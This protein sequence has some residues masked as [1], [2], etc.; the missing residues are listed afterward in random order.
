MTDRVAKQSNFRKLTAADSEAV[1]KAT[2]DPNISLHYMAAIIQDPLP[3]INPLARW[4]FRK[5]LA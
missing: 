4:I 5:T 3:P 2:M 1:Y